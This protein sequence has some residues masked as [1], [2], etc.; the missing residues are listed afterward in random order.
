MSRSGEETVIVKAPVNRV[1]G[2]GAMAVVFG[3]AR[4]LVTEDERPLH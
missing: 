3:S 4:W 2:Y 1:I